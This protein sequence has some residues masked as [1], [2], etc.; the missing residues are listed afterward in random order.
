VQI[1]AV[2]FDM[3]GVLIDAKEWHYEALNRALGLFGMPISR[4][5]HLVT[6]DGLPTRK[7]LEMLSLERDLPRGLHKFLNNLKQRY[8][9][10]LVHTKCKPTFHHQYALSKLKAAGF[11][12][13]L[14][15]N[16][17][18][19]TLDLMCEKAQILHYF[20]ATLS[21]EDVSNPKPAPD[22]YLKM[23]ERL[24]LKPE[25][26]LVVEDNDHG[27]KAALAAGCHLSRVSSV[28]EI[29]LDNLERWLSKVQEKAA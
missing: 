25:E 27:V 29:T 10:E 5:D 16:S 20:D 19:M 12:L 9:L 22:M 24:G 4:Y 2:V 17:I 23:A 6:Y 1:K 13:G 28:D 7:K 26:V 21:N 8:T 11:K 3:D 18:R 14:C 15:S